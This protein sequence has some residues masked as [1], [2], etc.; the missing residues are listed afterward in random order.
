MNASLHNCG[1]VFIALVA[2]M[3]SLLGLAPAHAQ[4]GGGYLMNEAAPG[5]YYPPMQPQMQY[6]YGRMSSMPNFIQQSMNGPQRMATAPSS[7]PRDNPMAARYRPTAPWQQRPQAPMESM[8]PQMYGGMG[9]EGA[10]PSDGHEPFVPPT[11]RRGTPAMGVSQIVAPFSE[12]EPQVQS[13]AA[14]QPGNPMRPMSDAHPEQIQPGMPMAEGEEPFFDQD[15]HPQHCNSC[16]DFG[17]C[18]GGVCDA[19]YGDPTVNDRWFIC[20]PLSFL[21]ESSVSTGTQAF[22]SPIDFGRAGNMGFN[23]AINL[24][25]AIWHRYGIGYQFGYR[26]AVSNLSGDQADG[27]GVPRVSTHY[28]TFA[29][30]GLFHRAFFGHGWQGGAVADYLNDKYYVQS[31]LFQLRME[32]SYVYRGGRE[33]GFTGALR[34]Q[35]H[36]GTYNGVPIT[37]SSINQYRLFYRRN[38]G[39]GANWRMWAGGTDNRAGLIGCDFRLPLSNRFDMTGGWNYMVE[40]TARRI[41]GLGEAWGMGLNLVFYPGRARCGVHN[42]PYRALFDVADNSV[43]FLNL[44]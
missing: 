42:G 34:T 19:C 36:T 35:S 3:G 22:K 12:D 16:G 18:S 29:T 43:Y 39:N 7:I 21:N 23:S 10:Y 5:G 33:F 9:G 26:G 44:Q 17:S 28:Q 37:V 8:Q 2:A 13:G 4:Y 14:A 40:D 15:F 30:A 20:S 11:R 1:R 24:S 38:F 6:P 41:G 25:D 31:D 27:T 32:L